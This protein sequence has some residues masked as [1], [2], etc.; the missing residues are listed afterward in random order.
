M[1]RRF[2]EVRPT[3][4]LQAE[5]YTGCH[6]SSIKRNG[7]N[8]THFESY[9]T[10]RT[11][12]H[13]AVKRNVLR[14][15]GS[16]EYTNMQRFG[17]PPPA[18]FRLSSSSH[19]GNLSKYDRS[20]PSAEHCFTGLRSLWLAVP[21]GL[22]GG[23]FV[24]TPVKQGWCYVVKARVFHEVASPSAGKN[25]GPEAELTTRLALWDM[26]DLKK[27]S[28][29]AMKRG[30]WEVSE[31][32]TNRGLCVVLWFYFDIFEEEYDDGESPRRYRY[33]GT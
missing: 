22:T 16:H 14:Q 26:R 31:G 11:R 28:T 6:C 1:R 21:P 4:L 23:T 27:M 8:S 15:P 3:T 9:C 20:S 7:Y 13:P 33:M 19:R 25:K 17:L 24:D 12:Y 10:L 5:G 30:Q 29:P 32:R 2:D 18:P